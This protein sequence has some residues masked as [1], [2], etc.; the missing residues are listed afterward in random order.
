MH[1][2]RRKAIGILLI[3]LTLF[4]LA[5]VFAYAQYKRKI[6]ILNIGL[7]YA[8]E[9]LIVLALSI[10]SIVRVVY[11]LFRVERHHEYENRMK[12]YVEERY[13]KK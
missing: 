4:F 12:K 7:S 3:L 11:E 13:L 1:N 6:P 2:Y 8:E 9:D 10:A 5:S